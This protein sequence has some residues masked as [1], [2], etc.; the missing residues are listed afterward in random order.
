MPIESN[1]KQNRS[2]AAKTAFKKCP[3]ARQREDRAA[4]VQVT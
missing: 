2:S 4:S 1:A 3:L